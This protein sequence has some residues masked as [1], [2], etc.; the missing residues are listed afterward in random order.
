MTKIIEMMYKV[1]DAWV[2]LLSDGTEATISDK[3]GAVVGDKVL[4]WLD[5]TYNRIKCRPV[6]KPKDN[7]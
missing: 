3:Y 4:V 6:S 7:T 5:P 2:V 1:K